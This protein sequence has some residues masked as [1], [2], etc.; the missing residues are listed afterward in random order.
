MTEVD[1]TYLQYLFSE[2]TVYFIPN[3]EVLAKPDVKNEIATRHN[4]ENPVKVQNIENVT[5]APVAPVAEP[6]SIPYNPK[7]QVLVIVQHINE[8]ELAFLTKILNA[9]NLQIN[10]VDLLDLSK[11]GNASLK[12]LLTEKS[13]NQLL[14]FGVSLFKINLEIPLTPYQTREIQGVKLLYSDALGEIKDDLNCKKALWA[15]MKILFA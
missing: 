2:E 12:A 4:S 15:A 6:D 1:K 9:V 3:K 7:H 13:V 5:T 11:I 8:E 14:T 10:Q